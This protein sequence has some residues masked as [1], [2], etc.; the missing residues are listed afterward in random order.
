MT[1][2]DHF[3]FDIFFSYN[4]KSAQTNVKALHNKLEAK[5]PSIRI[6]V[7]YKMISTEPLMEQ[8]VNGIE[9]SKAVICFI[10][11][12]Y[13]NSEIC[14]KELHF[15]QTENKVVI[16]VMLDHLSQINKTTK[17]LI[18]TNRHINI[19][20]NIARNIDDVWSGSDYEDLLRSVE[21]A[22]KTNKGSLQAQLEGQKT[23]Q[24]LD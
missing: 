6:C 12:D 13:S 3:D 23:L 17:F 14:R 22:L 16:I 20:R 18:S 5:Y 24:V 15:A 9:K 1:E 8:I 4:Q 21:S 19:Y 2:T 10:T 7:D 11:K